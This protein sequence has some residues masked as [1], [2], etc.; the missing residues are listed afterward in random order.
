MTVESTVRSR[1]ELTWDG[2]R[3]DW[4][5]ADNEFVQLMMQK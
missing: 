1:S 5:N 2:V 3:A 4:D